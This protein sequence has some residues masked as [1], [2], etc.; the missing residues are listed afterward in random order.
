M[1]R[2]VG[3]FFMPGFLGA[4]L[5]RRPCRLADHAAEVAALECR[6]LVRK[7]VSLDVAECRFRFALDAVVEGLNDVFLE[8]AAARM[9][10]DHGT[11]LG[12]AVLGIGQAQPI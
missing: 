4:S 1:D 7:N 8:A 6:V 12:I 9:G 10:L 3:F 11:S 2:P 5:S